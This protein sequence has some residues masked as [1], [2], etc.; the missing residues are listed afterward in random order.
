[1]PTASDLLGVPVPSDAPAFLLAL[2]A[3]I[4][5][6][7]SAVVAGAVAA[8]SRKRPG[9][10]PR[11]GLIYWWGLLWMLISSLMMGA[12]RWPH[13]THLIVIG[14]AAFGAG[15]AGFAVR[16]RAPQR[17][18]EV[19]LVAM[20]VSY[21]AL[22]TGFYVDNGP[23][24]PGWRTLPGWSFWLLPAVVGVPLILTSL[25]RWRAREPKS[26]RS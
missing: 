20:G 22:L 2:G 7:L 1:M 13:D 15:S 10:H 12:M 17:W 4:A 14:L 24:L 26:S 18:R 19:H 23:H 3:H 21:T 9:L 5:A 6:G 11:A 16:V 25:R 8:F